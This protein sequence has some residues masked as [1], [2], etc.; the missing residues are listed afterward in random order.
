MQRHLVL[1]WI[2]GVRASL[3]KCQAKRRGHGPVGPAL[4]A[5]LSR[6]GTDQ[7][8]E[9]PRRGLIRLL[10]SLVPERVRII[11]LADRGFGRTELART[12]LGMVNVSFVIRIKPQV[13]VGHKTFTGKQVD[14]PVK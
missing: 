5:Q 8:P 6:V 9:Q 12:L 13:K 1:S 10:R 2:L 3:R 7:E 14:Y 4:V 11:L